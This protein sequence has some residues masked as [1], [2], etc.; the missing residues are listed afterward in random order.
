MLPVA[1]TAKVP[2]GR[3]GEAVAGTEAGTEPGAGA[4][5]AL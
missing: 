3:G 5:A 4:D 2:A 1:G